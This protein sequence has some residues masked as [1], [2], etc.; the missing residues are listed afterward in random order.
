MLLIFAGTA[1]MESVPYLFDVWCE[2]ECDRSWLSPFLF[3]CVCVCLSGDDD[4]DDD[5]DA[6]GPFQE[7]DQELG[8]WGVCRTRQHENPVRKRVC[9]MCL[10]CGGLLFL[11][12]IW[13]YFRVAYVDVI[14]F[15]NGGGFV[16]AEVLLCVM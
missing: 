15:W 16:D 12:V 8:A 13:R 10:L 2:D 3:V 11:H 9:V 14:L 1:R 5:D 4:D 6:Q 7:L